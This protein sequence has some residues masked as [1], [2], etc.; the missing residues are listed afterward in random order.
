MNK[1]PVSGLILATLMGST[2]T[3]ALAATHANVDVLGNKPAVTQVANLSV[4]NSEYE[5]RGTIKAINEMKAYI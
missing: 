4:E 1:V 3:L 2:I 5:I